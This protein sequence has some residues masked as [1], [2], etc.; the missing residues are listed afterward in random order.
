M[1][2]EVVASLQSSTY[3]KD[4]AQKHIKLYSRSKRSSTT[5]ICNKP[6]N[7]HRKPKPKAR[8]VSGSKCRAASF[9]FNF[10]KASFKSS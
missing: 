7:Q 10:D 8:E 6:K 1:T 2:Q 4:Y 3:G 5:S 9:N